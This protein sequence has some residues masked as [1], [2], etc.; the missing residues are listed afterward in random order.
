MTAE[1]AT[2]EPK[3]YSRAEITALDKRKETVDAIR[4]KN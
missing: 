2:T 1:K 4:Q 3:E